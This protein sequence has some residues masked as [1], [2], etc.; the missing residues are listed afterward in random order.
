MTQSPTSSMIPPHLPGTDPL[1]PH[2]LWRRWL[3]VVAIIA[4]GALIVITGWLG[5]VIVVMVKL[6]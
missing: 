3:G 1:P 6:L 2:S 4:L 5:Y